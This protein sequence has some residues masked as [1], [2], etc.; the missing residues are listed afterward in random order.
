MRPLARLLT[1]VAGAKTWHVA[2]RKA[3]YL[4][5]AGV[6][7]LRA[8]GFTLPADIFGA[9]D[10]YRCYGAIVL[11]D[12]ACWKGLAAHDRKVLRVASQMLHAACCTLHV[13]RVASY[14]AHA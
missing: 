14:M 13:G 8:A 9:L 5:C 3:A 7:V 1:S 6:S 10:A 2:F 11:S 4:L 12:V